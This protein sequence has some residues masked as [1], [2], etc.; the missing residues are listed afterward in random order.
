[1]RTDWSAEAKKVFKSFS[2]AIEGIVHA[3]KMER[4]LRIHLTFT[5]LVCLFAVWFSVSITEWLIILLAIGAVISLELVNTA[6]ERVV[7]LVTEE[8]LPLAKQAK[9]VAAGAVFVFAIIAVII[10]L[11]IFLPKIFQILN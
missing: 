7:D 9:D 4:N 1:M 5:V 2:Y 10:G 6:L 8:H 11:V 3:V